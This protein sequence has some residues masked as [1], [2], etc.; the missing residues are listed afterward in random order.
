MRKPEWNSAKCM[1]KWSG[2]KTIIFG[3]FQTNCASENQAI[4]LESL[5]INNLQKNRKLSHS[6]QSI[7]WGEF[8]TKLKQKAA[9]YGTELHFAARFYAS[10]KTCFNC[11]AKQEMSLRERTFKCE[12]CGYRQHRDINAALNLRETI[13]NSSEY[14]REQTLRNVRPVRLRFNLAG[15]FDEVLTNE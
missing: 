14:E 10:T 8:L 1:R 12:S 13:K 5:S 11:Q 2:Y 9:E 4:G 7:S 15:S 3:I 6:I